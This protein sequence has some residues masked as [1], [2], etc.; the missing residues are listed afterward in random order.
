MDLSLCYYEAM[1]DEPENG[2]GGSA[3]LSLRSIQKSYRTKGGIFPALND[4]NLELGGHGI[5]SIIGPSGCGK[6]TL[7][8]L[9]GGLDRPDSG[10]FEINGTPTE[11]F[12][13][14]DW[15]A[16]R[17]RF[18]GFVFQNYNLIAY[19]TVLENVALPLQIAGVRKKERRKLALSA[20]RK[21]GLENLQKK[22]P[23]QLS[24]GQ[25][26][27][28]AVARSIVNNPSLI[29][30]DEPTGALDSES[31]VVVLDLLKEI[32]KERLI[33]LVTH[34]Q[35]LAERYSDR[36]IKMKD[37]RIL[38][39]TGFSKNEKISNPC[40][41]FQKKKVHMPLI[42]CLD[43]SLNTVAKKKS[44]IA[45]TTLSCSF[46]I[47]GVALI[48]AINNGFSAYVSA[49]EKS[50]ASSVPVSLSP[51]ST[52]THYERQDKGTEFPEDNNVNIYDSRKS[53]SEVVYNNFSNEYFS[54]LD[55][56]MDDPS[57]PAYGSAMSVMYYRKSLY[58]HFMRQD[59]SG[60]V[61]EINQ[62][63][64]AASSGYT[65]A[66]LTS[67]PG[68]ILHELYGNE[69]NMSSLYDTVAGTFPSKA[70]DL[71][72]VLDSY[73]RIDFRTMKALGF[74]SENA[75]LD[76]GNDVVSF[77]RILG[78]EFKCYTNSEYYGFKDADDLEA[79][80]MRR[81]FP[82]Y[83]SLSADVS[84]EDGDGVYD[85]KLL[86]SGL[87]DE[88]KEICEFVA[89]NVNDV[90][91]D[92]TAHKPIK[93]KIVGILR[94]KKGSYIQLM[95][96]SVAYTPALSKL[97]VADQENPVTRK[98]A[99]LQKN[100]WLLPRGPSSFCGFDGKERLS[101]A[102]QYLAKALTKIKK[103]NSV[104]EASNDL[105]NF[106]EKLSSAFCFMILPGASASRSFSYVTS[107]SSYLSFCRGYG[108]TF[109]LAN[110]QELLLEASLNNGLVLGSSFFSE[111]NEGNII[112]YLASMNAYSLVDSILIFPS[113][114]STKSV[115]ISYLDAWN[116]AHPDQTND[117]LDIMTDFTSS[118][119]TLVQVLSIV[120]I[121]FA[122]ISL[123][124]SSI[125]TAIITYLSVLERTR[126]IGVLRSCG[127]RKRDVGR[128]FEFECLFV[129]LIAGAIGVAL[130]V[131]SCLPLNAFLNGMFPS[132]NLGQIARLN[133]LSGVILIAVSMMLSFLS[134]LIPSRVAA[135]KDPVICLRS[136]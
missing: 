36:I 105:A 27:R 97:I 61:R 2:I 37:G 80:L 33:V 50:V 91:N 95:P 49:V 8:N 41:C 34:N 21:V 56:L 23:N 108:A 58:F 99:E 55:A 127:A 22:R 102:F 38:S 81:T 62:Y 54:Y 5:V 10:V 107:P 93:C 104:D 103:T 73:N 128:L 83:N 44:R 94:P 46:G 1:S 125:M 7:L 123:V 89:P 98:M 30:A 132:N 65:I 11:S 116:D 87:D 67:L 100:N 3:S 57:C 130:A 77:E 20:L 106:K 66:S 53:Y 48:L 117:Y 9:L 47:L 42:S 79:N 43:S 12:K 120:L 39:D 112:D 63:Q 25:M 134:G 92:E 17:N 114:V 118:L 85:A 51:V 6:T 40:I 60:E 18:V 78:S 119:G 45:L 68:T 96:S 110:F 82:S 31:S 13:S 88:T 126:E 4:V 64:T 75:M 86:D 15:D 122:S 131:V 90:Y 136:E 26:Q 84:D 115:L 113:A 70:N 19:K 101:E 76:D 35:E 74:Y 16:Y 133:P 32:S 29:L 69:E 14:S 135:R 121:I 24:G 52:R 109:P 71:A 72:L 59:P 124:V 111:E 129:G 28:V